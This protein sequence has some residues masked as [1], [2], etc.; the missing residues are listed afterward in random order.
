MLMWRTVGLVHLLLANITQNLEVC[1]LS[2]KPPDKHAPLHLRTLT[3]LDPVLLRASFTL[4][5]IL[6]LHE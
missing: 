5:C 1:F 2:T 4:R 6:D 3:F